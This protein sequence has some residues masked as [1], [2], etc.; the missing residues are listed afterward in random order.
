MNLCAQVVSL[1]AE[2]LNFR[3][4]ENYEMSI[5]S[6]TAPLLETKHM[7]SKIMEKQTSKMSVPVQFF[8]ISLSL[9]EKCP[10]TEFF[11]GRIFPLS[12]VF[13]STD[14]KKLRIWTLSRSLF[15]FRTF[16]SALSVQKKFR[17]QLVQLYFKL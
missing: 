6:E 3:I 9:R 16:C 12:D 4:L 17:L 8:L 5:K 10:N 11:L 14:Q 2:R 15:L 1:V 13:H 7:L